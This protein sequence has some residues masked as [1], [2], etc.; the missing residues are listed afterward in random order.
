[1]NS[2]VTL[3]YSNIGDEEC[4]SQEYCLIVKQAM[5][6]IYKLFKQLD[7]LS[8]TA[9]ITLILHRHLKKQAMC[10]LTGATFRAEHPVCL[11]KSNLDSYLDS[12]VTTLMAAVLPHCMGHKHCLPVKIVKHCVRQKLVKQCSKLG[13]MGRE[14]DTG[15]KESQAGNKESQAGNKESKTGTKNPGNKEILLEGFPIFTDGE[16]R[17]D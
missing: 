15:N 10:R 7:M 8:L 14:R 12:Q 5:L 17:L 2:T 6:N 3:W 13:L 1:M 11:G 4:F 16:G 9:D